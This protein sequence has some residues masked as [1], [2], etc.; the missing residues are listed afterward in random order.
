VLASTR[1]ATLVSQKAGWRAVL[2]D[3][4]W[5]AA[6]GKSLAVLSVVLMDRN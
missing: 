4:N 2:M 6:K 3:G 5:A 1:A